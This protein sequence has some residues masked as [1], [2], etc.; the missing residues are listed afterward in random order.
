MK[1][2]LRILAVAVV[3]AVGAAAWVA[4]VRLR[5]APPPVQVSVTVASPWVPAPGPAPAVAAPASGS[6]AV[7]GVANGSI[8]HLVQADASAVRP[9]ASVAKAMTALVILEAHPLTGAD[10]GPVITIS[11]VDVD[12]YRHIAAQDGSVVPVSRG[13]RFTERDLLLGLMLP[14]ANNLALTAARWVDGT[15]A[16][17]VSHLNARAVTLAM[18]HTHFADPDG[19]DVNTTSTAADLV[20]LGEAVVANPQLLDV[21]S[22]G[23][24]TMPD[25]L[26]VTNLDQLLGT[27]PGWLGIKT[28]W[29]PQ[30]SGCLLF[31]ARRPA[32]P[33]LPTVTVVGAVLG[34]PPDAAVAAAH[35][36]LGGAFHAAQAAVDAGF[37]GY[38]WV[39]VGR[40]TIPL[41]G[42]VSTAWG[43]ESGV[44]IGGPDQSVLVHLGDAFALT[45]TSAPLAPPSSI[46]A[47]VGR[48]SVTRDG[49]PVGTWSLIAGTPIDGPSAWWRLQHD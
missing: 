32:P 2:A 40:S 29:T 8:V 48:L 25:G 17:F 1:L 22:A 31:A 14:S 3:C 13:E 5:A 30:A 42:L 39:T 9:I 35:P 41:K 43:E 24:A 46:D 34:Q 38:T 12:D 49:Q 16:A 47:R 21:V 7:D 20:L 15:V 6:L 26:V 45:A 28:G 44:G 4:V 23:S 33:G 10:P 11:Q 19:L 36:E 18:A 27:E 37:A